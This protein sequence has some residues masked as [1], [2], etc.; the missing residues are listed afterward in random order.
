ML[1]IS[2]E[3]FRTTYSGESF[4]YDFLKKNFPFEPRDNMYLPEHLPTLHPDSI[5]EREKEMVEEARRLA[6]SVSFFTT[7]QSKEAYYQRLTQ[8]RY[9]DKM[10]R[11]IIP[12]LYD[13]YDMSP[14]PLEIKY[15][16]A[17]GAPIGGIF[18][19][20]LEST[21]DDNFFYEWL[22]I[23]S[24]EE[25]EIV[26]TR[27]NE[28]ETPIRIEFWDCFCFSVEEHMSSTGSEPMKM[29][30]RL[31]PAIV[32]NRGFLHEKIWKI[33]DLNPQAQNANDDLSKMTVADAYW[34]NE[35]GEEIRDLSVEEPVT[36]Y[37]S[38][39]N[40]VANKSMQL[41]FEDKDENG[42]W[43]TANCSGTINEEGIIV[44]EDFKMDIVES[45]QPAD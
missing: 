43:R 33:T 45:T 13:L 26:I 2:Y 16:R 18:N 31:S 21:A 19:I 30:L 15:R 39:E 36:L 9:W 34:I 5:T 37:V 12:N 35:E 1:T 23:G 28:D 41:T 25:G 3:Y 10:D 29:R 38:I 44:L 4:Y 20:E 42:N 27:P 7:P 8:L 24:L 17:T 14:R 22:R 40:F 6:N 11:P 32:R